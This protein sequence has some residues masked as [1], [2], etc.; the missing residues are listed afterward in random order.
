[1]EKIL[2]I[3]QRIN[4]VM[5]EVSYVK[6]SDKKINNMYTFVTHDSVMAALQGPLVNNGIVLLP[7]VAELIQ[8]GNRTMVKM[9]ISFVN[10]DNPD[11]KITISHYGY[12]IDTQ[13]KGIGKAVSYAVKYALLKMFCLETGDDVEKDSIEHIPDENKKVKEEIQAKLNE[14]KNEI[15][16]LA[17][18]ENL[19]DLK[20]YLE[21]LKK[22]FKTRKEEE[23]ILGK[24]A[25]LFVQDF[26]NWKE[27]KA[28][29]A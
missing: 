13:D 5:K 7:T 22:S 6:K 23:I 12:G 14:R 17:G 21:N 27:K 20:A 15:A 1:M 18:K 24:D 10:I 2:N 25:E 9:E 26:L 29:A 19:Q 11:D 8:D 28:K 4:A 16:S 3:Y